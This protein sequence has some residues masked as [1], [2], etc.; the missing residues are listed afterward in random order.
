MRYPLKT[1]VGVADRR[2]QNQMREVVYISAKVHRGRLGASS[3]SEPWNEFLGLAAREGR[4]PRPRSA[5]ADGLAI[6]NLLPD[7]IR[8][9]RLA[10]IGSL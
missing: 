5:G 2:A 10:V 4:H 3:P 7:G 1:P 6:L 8:P 9:Y